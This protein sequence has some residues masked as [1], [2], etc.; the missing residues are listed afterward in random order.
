MV[1]GGLLGGAAVKGAIIG[2]IAGPWGTA[3]GFLAGAVVVIVAGIVAKFLG[4]HG[5]NAMGEVRN[6]LKAQL[7]S[8]LGD[9]M[10]EQ[11]QPLLVEEAAKAIEGPFREMRESAVRA[12][13]PLRE[14]RATVTTIVAELAEIDRMVCGAAPMEVRHEFA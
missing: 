12:L 2:S 11:V 5:A 13:A 10:L 9:A 6:T 8:R 1:V 14:D 3:A 4:G 7:R